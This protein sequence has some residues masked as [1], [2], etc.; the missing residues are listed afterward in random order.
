MSIL[1][2]I[3]IASNSRSESSSDNGCDEVRDQSAQGCNY[4]QSCDGLL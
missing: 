2:A 1:P 3:Q 4:R